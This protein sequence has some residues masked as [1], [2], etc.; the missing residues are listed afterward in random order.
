MAFGLVAQS[1]A[2][3]FRSSDEGL[4]LTLSKG[5]LLRLIGCSQMREDRAHTQLRM[6]T[7]ICPDTGKVSRRKA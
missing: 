4:S 5:N 6:L 1:L 7:E 3:R 2:Q